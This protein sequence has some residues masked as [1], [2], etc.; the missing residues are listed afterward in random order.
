MS[1]E[2]EDSK[3]KIIVALDCASRAEAAGLLRQ[4]GTKTGFFKI[5][6]QLFV[7]EGPDIVKA[8][9]E[10]GAR[11]FLD[12]KFHDI[13]NTVR[14]AVESAMQLGVDM[15]TIHAGGGAAM[16]EAAVAGRGS[17]DCALLGV[18][19][20]TSMERAVLESVGVQGAVEDQ[21]LRLAHVAKQGGLTG[22]VASP[23]ELCLLRQAFGPEFVIVT[24][25]VRPAGSE[26]NDQKRILTPRQAIDAGASHLVIGRPVTAASDPAA[27]LENILAEIQ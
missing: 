4:L 18:T 27:A 25:G 7:A 17:G 26:T 13:P 16:A 19:V 9:Q 3:L 23:L 11:V 1:T 22:V 10:S 20:L 14:H 8:V 12:L 5:G 15:L 2:L 21:V 24:P 6:L